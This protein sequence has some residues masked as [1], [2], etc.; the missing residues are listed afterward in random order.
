MAEARRVC[1]TCGAA[2]GGEA[3]FCPADG[4]PL[5]ARKP[6]GQDAYVGVELPGSIRLERLVGIGS[7]GRVYRASQRGLDRAVAVKILHKEHCRNETLVA[8]FHREARVAA[9]LLHPHVIDVHAVGELPGGEPYIVTEF[10]DGLSLRSAL[11]AN[12]GKI[13]EAR[14]IHV[15][16]QVSDALGE[17]HVRG[18]V[19]RDMKPENVMLV[20]CGADPEFAKVLD[21]GV[22]RVGDADSSVATHAGAILGTATYACPESA[23]G[24]RV[25]P[26]G[27][28]YSLAVVLFECLA[29]EPPFRGAGPVDVLIQHAQTPA[30]D[31]RSVPAG[32]RVPASLA[33]LLAQ[34]LSKNPSDRAPDARVFGRALA[35]AATEAGLDGPRLA[36]GTTLL[37]ALGEAET[38]ERQDAS[39]VTA[40]MPR[41]TLRNLGATGGR[42]T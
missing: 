27:D 3:L 30:P 16:L 41:S 24:D 40:S 12:G 35:V 37:G 32:S 34:N 5:G 31:V 22:A 33:H 7:M 1:P 15:A 8:R 6:D 26:P 20:R 39:P 18:V 4:A 21:F 13:A 25:G 14:A 28:V 23:R 17:A 19:H 29:G 42:P 9:S 2:Y 36:G 11:V 10:L 38:P